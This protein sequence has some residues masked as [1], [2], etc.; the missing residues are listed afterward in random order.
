MKLWTLVKVEYEGQC[1]GFDHFKTLVA[2]FEE[3][4]D[5]QTVAPFL[6]GLSDNMGE[7]ISEVST[8][9]RTGVLQ[10]HFNCEYELTAVETG[11]RLA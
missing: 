6:K 5:M 7:A 3:K 9:L 1:T 11:K 8:L 2:V 10:V 4:P